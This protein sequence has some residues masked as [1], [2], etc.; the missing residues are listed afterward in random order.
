M[1]AGVSGAAPDPLD[2]LREV[3]EAADNGSPWEWEHAYPQRIT[4][5]GDVILVADCFEDPDSPSR[6]AEFIAT[7]DPP[8]ALAL[9][10][11][12]RAARHTADDHRIPEPYVAELR[13][14]LARLDNQ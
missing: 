11:I 2:R 10:E 13:A 14:A 5:V 7:F 6:F 8:T 4:R 3:A 1:D 9:V 12:A